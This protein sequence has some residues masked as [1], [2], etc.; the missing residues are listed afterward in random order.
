[1]TLELKSRTSI[2]SRSQLD[3]CLTENKRWGIHKVLRQRR[4]GILRCPSRLYS[5]R[6]YRKRRA[7]EANL[8]VAARRRVED[9]KK[10]LIKR[11]VENYYS[12][13]DSLSRADSPYAA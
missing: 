2:L 11:N 13:L 8:E 3:I 4:I 9:A 7:P 12:I 5:I 1:M 10:Y 6:S